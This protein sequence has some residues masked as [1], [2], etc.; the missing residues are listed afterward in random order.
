MSNKD[1]AD[2]LQG[3]Q[4]VAK[5]CCGAGYT[6]TE[7]YLVC[8]AFIAASEDPFVGTAQKGKDFWKK[9]HEKYRELLSQQLHLAQLKYSL[10]I[11]DARLLILEPVIEERN[12][13]FHLV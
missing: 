4:V 13:E 11:A 5:I 7:D 6:C 2:N 12:Q 8:K 3:S 9:M 1:N 10:A